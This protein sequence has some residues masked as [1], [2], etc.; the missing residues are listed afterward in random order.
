MK[1]LHVIIS[2]LLVLGAITFVSCKTKNKPENNHNEISMS[3]MRFDQD[4]MNRNKNTDSSFLVLYSTKIMEVEYPGS[5]MYNQ[6]D[7]IFHTDK[8]VLKLYQ[9]CQKQFGN[10]EIISKRLSEAFGKLHELFPEMNIPKLCMH[11]SYYGESIIS[12]EK[13][14]SASIDKYLG[15]DYPGYQSR[16]QPYQIQK[17]YKEKIV[18]DYMTGWLRSEFLINSGSVTDCLLDYMVYEG[19]LL[20]LLKII[21]PK[22]NMQNFTGFN[23]E[24]LNWCMKNE[25]KMWDALSKF[26]HLYTTDRLTIA[27]YIEDAPNT[28]FFPV[29]SPGRAI[30]WNGNKIVEYYMKNNKDVTVRDLMLN[31]DSRKIL[32]SSLYHP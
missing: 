25:K 19:K 7:S 5:E 29:E 26:Q 27:K 11:I 32:A 3:I 13:F 6:F 17:M 21:L 20:Y 1:L 8:E 24:Q 4:F 22:E 31:N 16:F 18:T 12:S 9:D 28:S 30:I 14:L 23:E 2:L 15:K 10:T